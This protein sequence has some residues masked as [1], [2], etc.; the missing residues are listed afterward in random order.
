M[1]NIFKKNNGVEKREISNIDLDERLKGAFFGFFVGDALG[2]P[3]EFMRREELKKNKVT[4]MREFGSHNQ[5]KGTWSDDSSMVIATMD[6]IIK[7]NGINYDDIMNSFFNWYY[8]EEY[9]PNGIVF[10]IGNA[11]RKAIEKYKYDKSTFI[12]GENSEYS[13]GNGSLMRILPISLLL[14]FSGNKNIYEIINNISSMT[15]SHMYSVF[16]CIFYTFLIEQY[17]TRPHIRNTYEIV[18][19]EINEKVLNTLEAEYGWD[20]NDLK[21]KYSRLLEGDISKL[22]EDE[23][24]SSGFVIDSLEASIWCV[25]TSNS[26]KEAVLK[27]V[28]LGEDTDTI[29]ALTGALAGLLYGYNDIPEEWINVLKRKEYLGKLVDD[30]IECIKNIV[31]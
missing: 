31:Y 5:E 3:V 14:Y 20:I 13:N 23:I 18:K 11:T 29:G 21:S 15:H 7:N 17:I 9:T 4:D 10:D 30:Y 12:C 26:Y 28:N 19:M 1:F 8:K 27:A 16:A 25:L 24:K 22:K 2:V 6:S